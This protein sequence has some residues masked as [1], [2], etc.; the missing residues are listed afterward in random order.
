MICITVANGHLDVQG[1]PPGIGIGIV[2][3]TRPLTY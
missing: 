3:S 2:R 1:A